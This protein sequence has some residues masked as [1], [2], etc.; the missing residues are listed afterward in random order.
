MKLRA[1]L[2][3]GMIL[4]GG[5]ALA[6]EA[7]LTFGAVTYWHGWAGQD[8]GIDHVNVMTGIRLASGESWRIYGGLQMTDFTPTYDHGLLVK[9]DQGG[10]GPMLYFVGDVV[11]GPRTSS[12]HPVFAVIVFGSYLNDMVQEGDADM[13]AGGEGG[14]GLRIM[15]NDDVH[16]VP[17]FA[18]HSAYGGFVDTRSIGGGVVIMDPAEKIVAVPVGIGKAAVKGI[19][20][21]AAAVSSISIGVD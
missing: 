11:W 21:V 17:G 1:L 7:P 2:A 3:A 8:D 9:R 19:K 15:A 16:I 10:L 12:G 6:Q 4:V 14:I 18:W 20:A 13:A 5:P